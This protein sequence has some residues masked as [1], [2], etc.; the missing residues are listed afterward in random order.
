MKARNAM[1]LILLLSLDDHLGMAGLCRGPGLLLSI[2][3]VMD[4]IAELRHD[5]ALLKRERRAAGAGSVLGADSPPHG[6]RFGTAA[7]TAHP[8]AKSFGPTDDVSEDVDKDVA[9]MVNHL[10]TNGMWAEDYKHILND[11]IT[12]R[13]SNCQVLSPVECNVQVLDA[14]NSKARKSDF[15]LKEVSK[16][17]VKAASIVV[18][19]LTILDRVANDEEH[20][21]VAQE[22]ARLNG[23]LALLGNTNFRNNLTRR[24]IIKRE[25]NQKYAHLCSSKI[26]MTQLLFGN[27]VGL[28][29]VVSLGGLLFAAP[30]RGIIPMDNAEA[31]RREIASTPLHVQPRCQKT[32]GA[33]DTAIPGTNPG[34]AT[35]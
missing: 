4:A 33:G 26:L 30:R 9:G 11:D 29:L 2:T 13:P 22:V 28:D 15:C 35:V 32:R 16:D 3:V 18:K 21:V 6:S 25:I 23:A 20:T 31:A 8:D 7:D 17:F 14:L 34:G 10:F 27:L 5:M 24:H 1:L 12:K 19:S